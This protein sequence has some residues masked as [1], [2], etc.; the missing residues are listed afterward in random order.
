VDVGHVNAVAVDG[1]ALLVGLGF[2]RPP[3][4][5]RWTATREAGLRL[6]RRIRLG[7]PAEAL[8]ERWRALPR[9][10]AGPA[11]LAVTPGQVRVEDAPQERPGWSWAVV[12][13]T[14]PL[15]RARARVVA[16]Q[17]AGGVPAHN[18]LPLDGL[19]AVADSARGRLVG[20]DRQSGAIVRSVQLPGELPFPRG[21]CSLGGARV[22]VGTRDP[23]ALTI[24]DLEA[25]RIEE[26]IELPDDR[27]ESPYAVIP[28]PAAFEDPAGRLPVSRAGWGV[29]GGDASA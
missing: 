5:L 2:V 26:R 18:A 21:I 20:V 10:A 28:L 9:N 16:Q 23:A 17:P 7:R 22:V 29:A 11:L 25:E 12:E 19:V 3:V 8:V 13:V 1:H 24:V 15:G 27:G 4:P 14:D 6:A